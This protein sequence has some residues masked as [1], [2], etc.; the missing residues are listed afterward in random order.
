[1]DETAHE[2]KGDVT[3]LEAGAALGSSDL[4][5]M[6][7]HVQGQILLTLHIGCADIHKYF[8]GKFW[9]LTDTPE[10]EKKDTE[11]LSDEE[12]GVRNSP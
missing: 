5:A 12:I 8:G 4:A 11:E 9:W 7:V 2:S 1:M 3:E 6:I 10:M